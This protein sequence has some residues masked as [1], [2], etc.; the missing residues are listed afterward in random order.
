M[1]VALLVAIGPLGARMVAADPPHYGNALDWV[2]GS[3]AFFSSSL[4]NKEQ[5]D[6][7][8]NSKAWAKLT[9][10]QFVQMGVQQFQMFYGMGLGP[11]GPLHAA[12][13][14]PDNQQLV[15]LVGDLVSHEMA[16]YGDQHAADLTGLTINVLRK[17]GN[18]ANG[19]DEDDSAGSSPQHR[20]STM[21]MARNMF[22]ELNRNIDK[23]QTPTLV[24]AMK[25]TDAARVQAQLARLEKAATEGL[26]NDPQFQGR[27][28]RTKVGNYEFLTLKLD[29]QMIPW[30]QVPLA[31]IENKPH[32]FDQLVD[33]LKQLQLVVSLGLRDD[34]LIFSIGPST[35]HLAAI[36]TGPRMVERDEFKLLAP[37]A[38]KRLVSV[39][40]V[41]K[42]ANA[43]LGGGNDLES[44][45]NTI[46]NML[47]SKM[48]AELKHR[49]RGDLES[50]VK[51]FAE[52]MPT[53]GATM[54]ATTLTDRGYD[55]LSYN[56]GG[57]EQLDGSKPLDVL[58]H[59]GGTPLA[60]VA[61]RHKP[62][63]DAYKKL[64]KWIVVGHH[65]FE[66]L[67]LPRMKPDEQ[68]Q[69]HD[70]MEYAKPLFARLDKATGE[71]LIPAMADGQEGL[72]LGCQD[73]QP[74]L[75]PRTCFPPANRR[76]RCSSRRS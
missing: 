50:M 43:I 49:I 41:S 29:G 51:D 3:A 22:V 26:A 52:Y 69:Y 12:L 5:W 21:T 4:R 71:M 34:Y 66:E 59:L 27:F 35:D 67:Q 9:S 60:A 39:E 31:K 30:D 68:K 1:V 19:S 24:L 54:G 53:P 62:T 14:N 73:H 17:L 76:C 56:W 46:V 36:G 45:P 16:A 8:V 10:L 40:F 64:V 48:P 15:S 75:V 42:E 13:Q 61:S 28:A 33:R 65:Y 63:P 37:L 11:M 70:F 7:L 58:D 44:V 32:E 20:D 57:N 6:I 72:C 23:I 55:C 38:D 47:P 18:G 2:P 25:H 74:P